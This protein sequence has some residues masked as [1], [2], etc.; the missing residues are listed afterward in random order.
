MEGA[1][2]GG[3]DGI[4]A[5][6]APA[7][8]VMGPAAPSAA[9]L[10]AAAAY[11]KDLEEDDEEA[12]GAGEP[13]AGAGPRY[14]DDD[15]LVGPVPPELALELDAVPQDDREAEVCVES[16][17]CPLIL[18][19]RPAA[20]AGQSS[21]P[22]AVRHQAFNAWGIWT[23][24]CGCQGALCRKGN[25]ALCSLAGGCV[26]VREIGQLWWLLSFLPPHHPFSV[27]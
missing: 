9:M 7:K 16:G 12:E 26:S 24:A 1:G 25:D 15:E 14:E 8:R 3:S 17:V 5:A 27:S 22:C 6:P 2:G 23:E 13:G 19:C 21:F 11:M 18:A 4:G 20:G 10:A